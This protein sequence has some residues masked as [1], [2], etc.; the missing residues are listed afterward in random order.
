M[1]GEKSFQ[2]LFFDLA[3]GSL[4]LEM[5]EAPPT[6]REIMT[7]GIVVNAPSLETE[8]GQTPREDELE[9]RP[10]SDDDRSLDSARKVTKDLEIAGHEWQHESGQPATYATTTTTTT[11]INDGMTSSKSTNAMVESR[12]VLHPMDGPTTAPVLMAGARPLAPSPAHSSP[13]PPNPTVQATTATHA[14]TT[15]PQPVPSYVPQTQ[16]P[17]LA[18]MP[19]AG[20]GQASTNS[21]AGVAATAPLAVVSN[22]STETPLMTFAAP[23]SATAGSSN[24]KATTTTPAGQGKVKPGSTLRRGKVRM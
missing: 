18:P 12:C 23:S 20:R 22:A 24:I 17:L 3:F 6:P 15:A 11:S 10:N 16:Q 2:K 7:G 8:S 4:N 19:A 1:T 9:S 13:P 14:F 5:T 21:S